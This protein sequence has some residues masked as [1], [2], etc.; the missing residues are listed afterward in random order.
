M[1][2]R[3]LSPLAVSA[4]GII[5]EEPRH[6]YEVFRLMMRRREDRVVKI[7]PGT[8]YHTID[9]LAADGLL[10]V[11]GTDR[12]GNRPERTTYA[13]TTSG[14]ALL[15]ATVRGMLARPVP[16]YPRFPVAIGEAH[17]LDAADATAALTERLEAL[18]TELGLVETGIAT[19]LRIELPPVLWLDIS[20]QHAQLSAEIGWLEQLL[21]DIRDGI[22]DWA[23]RSTVTDEVLDQIG[24]PTPLF[25]SPPK[26]RT[27]LQPRR[28]TA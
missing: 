26:T 15:T 3:E 22:V 10:E 2:D 27:A 9:N 23:A 6:P 13:I 18:R 25:P 4:L 16:E 28:T 12:E 14:R 17:N 11:V 24:L 8:L 19:V 7:R 5:W 1:A 21:A 20:Y